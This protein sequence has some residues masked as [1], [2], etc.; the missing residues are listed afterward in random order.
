MIKVLTDSIALN[1]TYD[2]VNVD[3]GTYKGEIHVD[4]YGR[5]VP[6]GLNKSVSLT[7]CTSSSK[8][9]REAFLDIYDKYTDRKLYIRKLNLTV[10][11]LT[12]DGFQQFD[13]FTDQTQLEREKKMQHAMLDIK[14][15]Y[16][17]NAVLRGLSYEESA[18]TRT[19][20]GQIG[21]HKA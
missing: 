6:Q 13:M 11:N 10:A 1:V 20:N 3:K 12:N 14:K 8:Q 19:R 2:R 17:K 18:T 7:T 9:L 16:G 15:K 5:E 4:R 21:G